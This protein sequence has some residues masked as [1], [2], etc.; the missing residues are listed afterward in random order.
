MRGYFTFNEKNLVE[1][2]QGGQRTNIAFTM[3]LTVTI[4]DSE[5]FIGDP[6]H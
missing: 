3:H 2:F 4:P 6:Y 1:V 5:H